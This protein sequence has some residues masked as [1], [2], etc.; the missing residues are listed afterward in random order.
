MCQLI[1]RGLLGDYSS[2]RVYKKIWS[3][4]SGKSCFALGLIFLSKFS[5][6]VTFAISSLNFVQL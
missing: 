1:E 5:F 4:S 2:L 3:V 6:A